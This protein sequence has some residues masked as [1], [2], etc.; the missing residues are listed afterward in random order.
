MLDNSTLRTFR[1]QLCVCVCTC[2]CVYVGVNFLSQEIVLVLNVRYRKEFL[3]SA[4][5]KVIFH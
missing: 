4:A 2:V 1:V 5:L 3:F